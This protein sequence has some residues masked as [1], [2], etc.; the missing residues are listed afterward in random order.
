[1]H[2]YLLDHR[3]N[4]GIISL[5]SYAREIGVK[6]KH[7]LE[8]LMNSDYGWFVQDDLREG[9]NLGV[10]EIPALF[11]NKVQFTKE[12]TIKNLRSYIDSL[13][14][15]PANLQSQKRA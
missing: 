3:T 13:F 6:D 12:I 14:K 2:Q 7:F 1:M 15:E 11:I 4:L 5:K 10:I 9:I 8:H